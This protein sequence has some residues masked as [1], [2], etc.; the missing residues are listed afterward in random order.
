MKTLESVGEKERLLGLARAYLGSG[1]FFSGILALIFG[2][3]LTLFAYLILRTQFIYLALPSITPASAP[4]I[5]L[6]LL[7][8]PTLLSD[9]RI[10]S[11]ELMGIACTTAIIVII[12]ASAWPAVNFSGAPVV[13][14]KDLFLPFGIILFALAGWTGVEPAYESKKRGG[15]SGSPFG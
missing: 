2:L 9:R 5:F 3:F 15:G 11:L 14:T 4:L 8:P 7:S 13:D 1:G 10:V 12:F 6:L